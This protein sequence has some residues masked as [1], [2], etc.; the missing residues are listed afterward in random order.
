MASPPSQLPQAS[1]CFLNWKI[2]PDPHRPVSGG[3][4]HVRLHS[5]QNL[6]SAMAW[7]AGRC[8]PRPQLGE[9]RSLQGA[10]RSPLLTWQQLVPRLGGQEKDRAASSPPGTVAAAVCHPRLL[11]GRGSDDHSDRQASCLWSTPT[12]PGFLSVLLNVISDEVS[13]FHFYASKNPGRYLMTE[14][15][16]ETPSPPWHPH[17]PRGPSTL[18]ASVAAR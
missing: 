16:S 15:P 14:G 8:L 12:P 13:W 2:A 3:S 11:L 10:Q 7:K 9:Y 5:R 4:N 6:P 17:L 18:R 1:G